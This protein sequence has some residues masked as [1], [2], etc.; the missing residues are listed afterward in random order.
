[1]I[2]IDLKNPMHH[3]AT[4]KL[5]GWEPHHDGDTLVLRRGVGDDI[6][7]KPL[8]VDC[9]EISIQPDRIR[10]SRGRSGEQPIFFW[11]GS[12][13]LVVGSDANEIANSTAE[14]LDALSAYSFIYFEY[15]GPGRSLFHE[16]RQL[17]NGETLEVDLKNSSLS[18]PEIRDDFELPSV[19]LPNH[20]PEQL[21]QSLRD[22][23]TRAHERRVG[24]DPLILLSGGVDSQVMSVAM[25]RDLGLSNVAAATFFVEGAG[26][27]EVE[28][29]RQVAENLGLDWQPIGVEPNTPI[30]LSEIAETG[31]PYF[32]QAIF[33]R[34]YSQLGRTSGSTV[35]SGQDTRLHTPA[36]GSIDL[37]L[38]RYLFSNPTLPSVARMAGMI[39]M[40]F[41]KGRDLSNLTRRKIEMLSQ[42]GHFKSFVQH[43]YFKSRQFGFN[44]SAPLFEILENEIQA[45]L[46]GID[47]R[48]PR[49]AYNQIVRTN[50]RWQYAFDIGY[51]VEA[52]Q[53]HGLNVKLPFYDSELSDLSASLPFDLT[54]KIVEGRAGH[55]QTPVRVNKYLLR[56][57]Y[58][59]ELDDSLIFRDK[60]VCPT[61]YM[62]MNGGLK[63]ALSSFIHD[64]TMR[65]SDLAHILHLPE[66]RDIAASR[67]GKWREEDNWICNL[68]INAMIVWHHIQ[69]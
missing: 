43:R 30:D 13:R 46:Q 54:T 28:D 21:A 17:M 20:D 62:F 51:C 66:L 18:I 44:R 41:V 35:L 2:S 39:G 24:S 37:K 7:N 8:P 58:K 53:R 19:E 11:K 42:S 6:P 5:T 63:D 68:L 15:P 25:V 16:V 61:N 55:G 38:W 14:K 36:L 45:S 31:F 26:S 57:A 48:H 50:W 34:V 4:D 52:G 60:A 3:F 29:A 32:G 47:P 64:R 65:D 59:G 56:L 67:H 9:S 12:D 69:K 22:H 1:M 40:P 33:D 10:I 27:T 23:I 49:S